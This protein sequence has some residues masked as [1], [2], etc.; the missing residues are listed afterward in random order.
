MQCYTAFALDL[1]KAIHSSSNRPSSGN[2]AEDQACNAAGSG[3]SD[4]ANIAVATA[5][6]RTACTAAALRVLAA[7]GQVPVQEGA[8]E[9]LQLLQDVA[10]KHEPLHVLLAAV[11]G[12]I[13]VPAGNLK[14]EVGR[15]WIHGCFCISLLQVLAQPWCCSDP[16]VVNVQLLRSSNKATYY[17]STGPPIDNCSHY[18]IF[19]LRLTSSMCPHWPLLTLTRRSSSSC[20]LHPTG[21]CATLPLT[22]C[23][24]GCGT[25]ATAAAT[26]C[27]C[28]RPACA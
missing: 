12:N 13:G 9:L 24:R 27:G 2:A 26:S 17:E 10:A 21:L 28:C 6:A 4:S 18:T 16:I 7:A 8:E 19:P 5:A 3:G 11:C 20:W 25:I 23:W 22:G 14:H 15:P 1:L